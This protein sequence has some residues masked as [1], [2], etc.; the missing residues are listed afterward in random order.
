MPLPPRQMKV[1]AVAPYADD[2]HERAA[3]NEEAKEEEEKVDEEEELA[4]RR[5]PREEAKKSEAD[6]S[7]GFPVPAPRRTT[8]RNRDAEKR[9]RQAVADLEK[10]IAAIPILIDVRPSVRAWFEQRAELTPNDERSAMLHF[11]RSWVH[12]HKKNKKHKVIQILQAVGLTYTD[13][14]SDVYL[15]LYYASVDKPENAMI[16]G[17]ILA[18]SFVVQGVC[19]FFLHQPPRMVIAGL[20]GLKPVIDSYREATDAPPYPNQGMTNIAV[21]MCT[22]IIEAITEAA[23]QVRVWFYRRLSCHLP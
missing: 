6:G 15:C 8:L 12:L 5:E 2:E 11:A 3:Q 20:L 16:I 7:L 17:G 18:A 22:R 14:G 21:L 23:P 13:M 19:A 4:P 9:V 1:H 10:F